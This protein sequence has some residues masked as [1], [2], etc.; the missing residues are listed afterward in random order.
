MPFTIS[1][2]A[3]TLPFL[4]K[5]EAVGWR[6]AL[7][8]GAMAPDLLFPIPFF[9]E[10]GHTHSIK[11][12]FALDI[13]LAVFLAA[14]W[15]FVLARRVSRMPGLEPLGLR[16]PAMFS[17]RMTVFGAF[18]GG[19]THLSW[20]L[21]THYGSPLLVHPFFG[22]KVLEWH[23]ATLNVQ[24]LLWY[25]NSFVGFGIVL[26]WLR[27]HMHGRGRG[28]RKVFFSGPWLRLYA[29]FLLPYAAIVLLVTRGWLET[30]GRLMANLQYRLDLVRPAMLASFVCVLA[31]AW[32]ET[33]E[34]RS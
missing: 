33:R 3:A 15:V 5:S 27:R 4:R 8:I 20:D 10:R 26:F 34:K 14:V 22:R 21:F 17:I 13:P 9:G 24:S 18:V 30:A 25:L 6:P 2:T 11:G 19:A 31:V 7:A 23:G 28:V 16:D 1:H 29:A 32:W 12:L